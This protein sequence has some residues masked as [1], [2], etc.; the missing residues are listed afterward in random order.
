MDIIANWIWSDDSNGRVYN[1]CSVFR[2]DFKLTAQIPEAHLAITADTFYRLKVN[3]QWLNDGPCRSWPKHF[4]YDLYDLSGLLRTGTNR[5]EVT[6][7]YYG[8][9]DFHHLPQR[10]GFLAQLEAVDANGDKTVIATDPEWLVAEMPQ[11]KRDIPKLSIQQPPYEWFDNS[12]LEAPVWKNAVVVASTEGGPWKNLKARDC[13]MLSHREFLLRDFVSANRVMPPYSTI[14]VPTHQLLFPEDTTV[15]TTDAMPLVISFEI[16]SPREQEVALVPERVKIIVNGKDAVNGKW[17]FRSG[18]N[19]V[20]FF[21]D[22]MHGHINLYGLGFPSESGMSRSGM[23]NAV[24]V[25]FPE[26]TKLMLD[27]PSSAFN[28]EYRRIK[29]EFKTLTDNLKPVNRDEFM[30][31]F[32]QAEPLSPEALINDDANLSFEF[33]RV[34]PSHPGDVLHPEYILYP[35]D[36]CAVINPVPGRDIELCFDLGEQNIGYWNFTL[37]AKAGTIVDV[38]AIEYKT[39]TGIIQHTGINYRN[40]MRYICRDGINRYTSL[41][42]RSGRFIY[43]TLRNMTAPV[44][45]QSFRL[46]ESTYPVT[47]AGTFRCSDHALEKIH[48]ISLRTL[49]LCMEDTFTDCPL[50]EQT[51]WVGDARSESLFAMSSVG[52][53]DLVR[54]CI[55]LT[56][57]SLDNAPM[58]LSQTPTGWHNIIPVWSFMWSMSIYDYWFETGDTEF[59]REVWPMVKLNL[60]GASKCIDSATGLYSSPD[61]NLFDW[62]KCDHNQLIMLHNSLFYTEALRTAAE[63]SSIAGEPQYADTYLAQR[64]NLI[65]AINRTWDARHLAWPESIHADGQSSSEISIHTSMLAVLFDADC[66][67]NH[68]A[69]RANT[70][71][72]RAELIKI[73]SPFALF[74]LYAALE[75]IGLRRELLEAIRRDYQPMLD[76][77]ATTVWEKITSDFDPNTEFPTRSHCH[78][79]SSTP[80]YFLPRLVLGIIPV[81]PGCAKIQISPIVAGLEYASGVRPTIHGR[82]KVEWRKEGRKLYIHVNAPSNIE[83]EFL[84]NSTTFDLETELKRTAE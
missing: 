53:Y 57:Q 72:P 1:L 52:A 7:R 70:V 8:S 71:T 55:R 13:R 65:D 75:K 54:R 60:E 74:Y 67:N 19:F 40:S 77:D 49:K 62:S 14:A 29:Q 43:V 47:P 27:H 20:T 5:L 3:G 30:R 34:E 82:V 11:L 26:L 45:F 76:L 69:V 2:R 24:I 48:E 78:A 15:N 39:P 50:F 51:L 58:V 73:G 31:I 12:I 56:G 18:S 22:Q 80:L 46:V 23:R 79:W 41:K 16:D 33:R 36:C 63:L 61:W 35:D 4:Q 9:G 64:S 59:I 17:H 81:A 32:P 42:R 25:R 84:P 10:A 68:T 21:P 83:V 6:V 66:P 28:E 38:A 44:R 37:F